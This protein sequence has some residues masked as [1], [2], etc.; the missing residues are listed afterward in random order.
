MQI[1]LLYLIINLLALFLPRK[2]GVLS[3][4]LFGAIGNIDLEKV[5]LLG[6]IN[7]SRGGDGNGFYY[8]NQVFKAI[9][10]EKHFQDHVIKK[11]VIPVY[12]AKIF[13]GHTRKATHGSHSIDNT[14]PF[15]IKS[16]NESKKEMIFA[17][18]GQIFNIKEL[19]EK[20]D[21]DDSTI[22]VDSHLLGILI[23]KVGVKTILEEYVGYAALAWMYTNDKTTV[24][25]YH[26]ASKEYKTGIQIPEERPLFGLFLNGALYYSSLEEPLKFINE[27]ADREVFSFPTNTVFT[28]KNGKFQEKKLLEIERESSN[29]DIYSYKYP[30]QISSHGGVTT[31]ISTNSQ[32]T[33]VHSPRTAGVYTGYTDNYKDNTKTTAFII[34]TAPEYHAF[35]QFKMPKDDIFCWALRYYVRE[36]IVG[37]NSDNIRLANGALYVDKFERIFKRP[38]MIVNSNG[39]FSY[40]NDL[41]STH[42][43]VRNGKEYILELYF[44]YQGVMIQN[45]AHY[46]DLMKR[47][48]NHKN[49]KLQEQLT[50]KNTNFARIISSFSKYPVTCLDH[51]SCNINDNSRYLFYHNGKICS[52]GNQKPQMSDYTYDIKDGFLKSLTSLSEEKS[53]NDAEKLRKEIVDNI[54]YKYAFNL[55]RII[56]N[57]TKQIDIILRNNTIFLALK[58]YFKDYYSSSMK[59]DFTNLSETEKLSFISNKI[60]EF[61][62][63]EVVGKQSSVFEQ[64]QFFDKTMF[65]VFEEYLINTFC[66]ILKSP[67]KEIPFVDTLPDMDEYDNRNPID[68]TDESE[69][70]IDEEDVDEMSTFSSDEIEK[71]IETFIQEDFLYEN[72]CVFNLDK[73]SDL[74]QDIAY[75]M[76]KADTQLKAEIKQVLE[77]HKKQELLT[78]LENKI[79]L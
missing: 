4:G 73:G 32:R 22:K 9:G 40:L 46:K 72:G 39:D 51:D 2:K 42:K 67:Q 18:N 27:D 71:E 61:F 47:L 37:I 60:E 48:Y 52:F 57:S 54:D 74:S 64:I 28:I 10:T 43:L 23:D 15:I 59:S 45:K 17:H 31:G 77:K 14:H 24:Y 75:A 49:D 33:P 65:I 13:L 20:Y 62:E 63:Q 38:S 12:D 16:V 29:I 26:G 41:P 68:E 53:I 34:P 3:C 55:C 44:F 66:Q 8:N 76:F 58:E 35:N 50:D 69:E 70:V 79:T 7:D 21:V 5:K 6:L 11:P 56:I 36:K 19:C 25:L 1:I 30:K 78:F